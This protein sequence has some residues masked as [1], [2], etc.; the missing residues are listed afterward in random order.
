MRED[1]QF[2]LISLIKLIEVILRHACQNASL[3]SSP[4][5]HTYN[6]VVEMKFE[7]LSTPGFYMDHSTF[8]EGINLLKNR[9]KFCLLYDDALY[10]SGH[11]HGK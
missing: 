10:G 2:R 3:N 9:H 8:R 4:T 5:Q 11:A 6:Q 7:E 1:K